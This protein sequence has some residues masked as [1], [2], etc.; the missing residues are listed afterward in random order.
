MT[1]IDPKIK[2]NYTKT[3]K[4]IKDIKPILDKLIFKK[5]KPHKDL[6]EF[7]TM[8]EW[9]RIEKEWRAKHPILYVLREFYYI[10]YRLWNNEIS[11]I[12][13]RIKWFCQRGWRG[14][15]DFDVWSFDYYLADVISKGCK[16]LAKETHGYPCESSPEEWDIILKKISKEFE[17]YIKISDLEEGYNNLS[18]EEY[19]KKLDVM[20]DLLKKNFGSL[21]D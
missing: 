7:K 12:P 13:K 9:A 1:T 11:M 8:E 21:G 17:E 16:Q 6:Y 20:F 4:V 19:E 2:D 14:Y 15:S 3:P 18:R 5:D 10:L